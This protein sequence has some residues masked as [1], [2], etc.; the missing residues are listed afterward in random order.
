LEE[1]DC[2]DRRIRRPV[3]LAPKYRAEA[4]TRAEQYAP[5]IRELQQRGY[6]MRG[7]AVE[8]TKRKVE[9]PRG[10]AW[11]PQLVKRIVERLEGEARP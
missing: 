6:T 9:T 7:M 8:L 4:K 5:I 1:A 10:G 3:A 2:I 11:H